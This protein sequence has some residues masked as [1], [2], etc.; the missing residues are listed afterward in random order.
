MLAHQGK[1]DEAVIE[2][3]DALRLKPDSPEAH[4]NLGPVFLMAGSP[5]RACR[6]FPRRSV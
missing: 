4:N 5:K 6:I 3:N 2:L 1:L